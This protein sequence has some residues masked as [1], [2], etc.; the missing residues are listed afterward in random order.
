MQI[1]IYYEDRQVSRMI[2]ESAYSGLTL[3]A[4]IGGALGL[5][6]GS[7]LMTVVEIFD[8]VIVS[9]HRKMKRQ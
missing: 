5:I 6:L 4:D 9:L 2:Q 8:F 1:A 7:T 3:A